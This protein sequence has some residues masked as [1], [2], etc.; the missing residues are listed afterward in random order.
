MHVG[1]LIVREIL[2]R[3]LSFAL[4]TLSVVVAVG[5]L[6]AEYTLLHMHDLHTEQILAA[7]EA[8]T[9]EKMAKME[10]DYRIITKNMG[11]NIVILPKD[12]NL[13]DLYADDYASKYMPEEYCTTLANSKIVTIQHL[14]P[15]LQQKIKWPER[16]RTIILIGTRGEV[17]LLHQ[18]PK[19]P[20]LDPVATGTMVVGYEL[21][22]SLN[23]KVGDKVALLGREYTVGKC[24]PEQGN[25]DDITI[26]IPLRDAQELLGKKGLLNVILALECNCPS[27]DRVG[28]IRSD[29]SAILP[30]TQL[31]ELA[32]Q[33]IA[34]AEARNRA[35][36]AARDAI[37]AEKAQRARL[38]NELERFAAVLAP[39]VM[40]GAAVWIGFLAFANARERRTEIGILRAIGLRSL[41][42]LH[43]FLGKAVLMGTVG[44]LLGYIGGLIVGSLCGEVSSDHSNPLRLFD[45]RLLVL[46]MLLSPLLSALAA[47]I[48]AMM[49]AQQD[50]AVVLREE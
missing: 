20:I 7:K 49:A 14:L 9:K 35:A 31:I 13:S 12:Q 18:T 46:V 36:A 34:R 43:I 2:Y 29:I 23:L 39:L 15:C 48:P 27:I 17:P 33:A 38:R 32:S 1:R 10:D 16:R 8:E 50:P 19:S 47:W 37:A 5:C 25:K 21:H 30:D 22:H 45:P 44:A 6:V 40:I 24:Y 28:E 41:Q 26:W 4:G 3:K 42:I 11:F